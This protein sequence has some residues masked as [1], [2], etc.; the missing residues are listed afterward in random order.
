MRVL[1]GIAVLACLVAASPSTA[2]THDNCTVHGKPSEWLDNAAFKERAGNLTP[3]TPPLYVVNLDL[4]ADQRWNE[5]G[6]A[7]ASR[8][9]LII[10]YLKSF[11]P[12]FLYQ[13]LV[14]IAADI[15][16]YKGFEGYT[17]EMRGIAK[18]MNVPLGVVVVENLV[19]EL[20]HIG[21]NCSNWNNTGP[22]GQCKNNTV[23]G[24]F[25]VS[26]SRQREAGPAG[27]CTSIVAQ[28]TNG[29][30]V[31]GRNM[32][33]DLDS[34]LRQ[35]IIDVDYQSNGKTVF[36]GTSLVGFLGVLHGMVPGG[37]AFSMNA[38]CQGGYLLGNF[39]EALKLHGTTPPLL[40]RTALENTKTFADGV[41]A[42]SSANL[43]DEVYYT[44]SGVNSGEGAVVTRDRDPTTTDI[45]P[46]D[47]QDNIWF[48]LET[49]YD[50]WE[51]DPPSDDRRD[52]GNKY[53][54]SVGQNDISLDTM[55]QDVLLQWPVFNHHTDISA[56]M[57]PR[58]GRYDSIVWMDQ[59]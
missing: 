28:N 45:W 48:R 42:L 32:D 25:W 3:V 43:I 13:P 34:S 36:R 1:A 20:E 6:A 23:D 52:P 59:N 10:D 9:Y 46:L 57:C 19:Y 30:I 14:E 40:A 12:D 31:H 2:V 44:V 38:R 54:N 8:A 11:I 15:Q 53:M 16:N 29:T 7:Y 51:Q 33:W 17:D 24:M 41:K 58:T 50:H 47:I 37:W 27:F 49:N 26:K 55:F 21:V 22:T 18:A 4:P 5:I 35:F 56:L 39:I